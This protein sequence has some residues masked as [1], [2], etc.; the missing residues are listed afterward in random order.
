MI[1]RIVY[2]SEVQFLHQLQELPRPL[3]VC[4]LPFDF[5]YRVWE[6][7]EVFTINVLKLIIFFFGAIDFLATWLFVQKKPHMDPNIECP[8]PYRANFFP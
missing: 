2:L 7:P 8:P 5:V 6:W 3:P 4:G 1:C